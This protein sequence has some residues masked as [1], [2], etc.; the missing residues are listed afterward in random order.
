MQV[1][2]DDHDREALLAETADER[3]H[4]LGLGDTERCGR[5]VQD[6]ELGVPLHRLR[7]RDRLPL[8]AGERGDRLADRVDRRDGEGLQ[9]LG[10]PLL[11][12]RLLQ[13]LEPVVLLAAEVHVLDDV[14]VVAEGEVLVDDLD[15]EPGGVLRPVDVD[16]VALEQDLAAVA[17][18]ECR[19]CT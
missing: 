3:E 12:D 18:R 2:G 1:V 10:R 11:H 17:N 4:L 6:H 19:R 5:L 13:A 9:R 15:A 8:A 14:E 7:D 16:L